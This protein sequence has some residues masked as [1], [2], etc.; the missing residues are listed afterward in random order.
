[1][2]SMEVLLKTAQVQVMP[3][4]AHEQHPINLQL[5]S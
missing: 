4:I 2:A 5:D 3:A 1:M